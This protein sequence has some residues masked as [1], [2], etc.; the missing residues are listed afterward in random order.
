MPRFDDHVVPNIRDMSY[1]PAFAKACEKDHG[2]GSWTFGEILRLMFRPQSVID[3]GSGIG[4]T[5]APLYRAGVKCYAVDFSDAGNPYMEMVAPGLSGHFL[6]H[7][8][9]QP[10]R[11]GARYDLCVTVE[12]AEHLPPEAAET[13]VMSCCKAADTVVFTACPP[14]GH[15][16]PLHLNEQPFPYWV[17]K[18]ET[19]GYAVDEKRTGAL[20]A[21]M[22]NL[23][24]VVDYTIPSWLFDTY[25]AIFVKG[26]AE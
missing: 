9:S 5:L 6:Q 21:I 20:R 10:L 16:N 8:L 4:F 1:G 3:L 26:E 15:G 14:P 11:L 2:L 23:S 18:F 13:F 12:T 24:Q 7:D 25:L 22:R 17:E 19:H